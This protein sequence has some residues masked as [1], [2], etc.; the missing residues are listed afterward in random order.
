MLHVVSVFFATGSTVCAFCAYN[1]LLG[2]VVAPVLI[3]VWCMV[4]G[5]YRSC[6]GKR[7]HEVG[8]SGKRVAN[9]VT[10]YF[11]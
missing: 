2:L 4:S 3:V 10:F 8:N 9:L 7:L 1:A 11:E 5:A 6:D